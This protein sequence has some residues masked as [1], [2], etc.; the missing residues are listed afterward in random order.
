[1]PGV[2]SPGSTK[3]VKKIVIKVPVEEPLKKLNM[4]RTKKT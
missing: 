2:K 1:M 4:R 3:T